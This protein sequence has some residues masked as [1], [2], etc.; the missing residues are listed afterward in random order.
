MRVLSKHLLE[1]N[2]LE[3]EFPLEWHMSR[4]ER[5]AFIKLLEKVK[6][7]VSIEIGLPRVFHQ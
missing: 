3:E 2:F 7:K 5:Y 6:P 1:P 4:N